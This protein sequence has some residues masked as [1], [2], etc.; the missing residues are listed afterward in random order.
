MKKVVWILSLLV[1][2][3]VAI[4]TYNYVNTI[5]NTVIVGYLSSNH[6]SALFVAHEKAMFEKEGISVR[7]VPF[8]AGHELIEAA[9]SGLID[10]GYCGISPVTI[11]IDKGVPI[12]IVAAVNEEGS[13]VVVKNDSNIYEA[14]DLKFKK[15][16]IPQKGS[17]QDVLLKELLETN[18]INLDEV[19]ITESEV[20]YM[21]DSL[22]FNKFDAF[23][24]WEPYPSSAKFKNH[25]RI[26]LYSGDIWEEHP[27]CVLIA[28]EKFIKTDS[29]NLKK[30]VKAHD[31]ATNYINLNKEETA[32]ITANKLGTDLNV[33]NEGIKHV[34]F[35][36]FPSDN[37]INEVFNFIESQKELGY[38]KNNITK[39]KLFNLQ[40]L[41]QLS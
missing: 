35:V 28:T 27:C 32:L 6:D 12:K 36:S 40:Y 29:E 11:A 23:I 22:S 1:L 30:F 4:G 26:L 41:P 31:E 9:S 8:R 3:L 5:E 15:I 37:F 17:V 14:P 18:N 7:L 19:N 20:P 25:E 24:A 39:D 38:I 16:A 21:P 13:A 33:E 10:V 34:K 2:V